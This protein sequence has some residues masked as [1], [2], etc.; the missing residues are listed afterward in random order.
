MTSTETG[1]AFTGGGIR[2]AAFCSG[3]LRRLL[4]RNVEVDYLSC[5]SGGSYA[6]TAYLDWKYRNG[7]KDDP[8]WHQKFFDNR[9]KRAGYLCRWEKLL[10]GILDTTILLSLVLLVNFIE[11]IIMWGSYACPVAYIIDL[12]FG[13][14]L[15]EER[16]CNDVAAA[17]SFSTRDEGF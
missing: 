6:G 10:E 2:S 8:K 13:K 7:K 3:I 9:R 11:P 1:L 14:Y 12:L 17:K 4:E 16:N 5:V 15:R